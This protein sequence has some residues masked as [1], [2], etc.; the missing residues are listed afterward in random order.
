MS[1][2]GNF[3]EGLLEKSIFASR[4]LQAPL[5][6]GLILAQGIY[7]YQFLLELWHLAHSAATQT[8]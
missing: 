3:I 2:N 1:K 4:W 8:F 5:Y 6:L 7:V